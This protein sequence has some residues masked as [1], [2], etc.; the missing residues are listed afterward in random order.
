MK[1][2]NVIMVLVGLGAATWIGI[3]IYKSVTLKPNIPDN[4][5]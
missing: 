2:G 1:A 3:L 4:N 5:K